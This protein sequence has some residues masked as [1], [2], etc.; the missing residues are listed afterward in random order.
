MGEDGFDEFSGITRSV[1]DRDPFSV[2]RYGEGYGVG[3]C[4]GVVEEHTAG[5]RGEVGHVQA[6]EEEGRR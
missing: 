5:G 4:G 6:W 1:K 3:F 2:D